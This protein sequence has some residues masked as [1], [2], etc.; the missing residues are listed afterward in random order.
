MV[1]AK[2]GVGF[3]NNMS[4]ILLAVQ[5]M[6]AANLV[7]TR[8]IFLDARTKKYKKLYFYTLFSYK[9][10]KGTI[11]RNEKYTES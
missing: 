4:G 6:L 3:Q 11:L 5:Y 7:E 1:L 8:P 2:I 9:Y 10:M